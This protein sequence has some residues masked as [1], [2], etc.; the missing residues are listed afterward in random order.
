M[1]LQ[2]THMSH[3]ENT[4]L[5]GTAEDADLVA[6]SRAGDRDA[7]CR[8]VERYQRLLCSLAYSATGNLS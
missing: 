2:W 4:T 1:H 6:A 7:F 5:P 8:I 3:L